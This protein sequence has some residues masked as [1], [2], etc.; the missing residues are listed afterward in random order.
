VSFTFTVL[1]SSAMYPTVDRAASGYLV[2]TKDKRVWLD[3]GSGT[4]RHLQESCDWRDLDAIV[5]S[6]RHPDHTTDVFQ[7]YHARQYGDA[8]PKPPI[9]LYAPQETIDRLLSFV[10][11]LGDS[12]EL[13]PIAPEGEVEVGDA[14][15]SFV[16]MAHPA[17]TLGIRIENDGSVLAYSADTGAGADF[18]T[19]ARDADVFVCEATFQDVDEEWEGHLRA[20]QAGQIAAQ[21]GCGRLVLTHLPAD[22]DLAHS[23]EQAQAMASG[24]TVALAEDR[25]RLTV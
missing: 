7:G 17:V 5:L 9:P 25:M 22:R 12:F 8:E 18:K 19:L 13:N 2:E 20:S 21:Q 11:D 10:E 1:G 6:H 14:R 3:A 15:L 23:L 24:V 16:R 4:W